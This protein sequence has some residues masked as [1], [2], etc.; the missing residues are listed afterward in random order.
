MDSNTRTEDGKA[1]NVTKLIPDE[2]WTCPFNFCIFILNKIDIIRSG[3]GAS[4]YF[5]VF[6]K[7]NR[8]WSFLQ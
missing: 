4:N 8:W 5:K 7:N 2:A 6:N 1:Y 3:P